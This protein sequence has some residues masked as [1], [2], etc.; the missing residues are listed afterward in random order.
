[1]PNVAA[2]CR[3]FALLIVLWRSPTRSRARAREGDFAATGADDDDNC[4]RREKHVPGTFSDR[5][6]MQ[7]P[8]FAALIRDRNYRG[9]LWNPNRGP[10]SA[11][12]DRLSLAIFGYN[13]PLAH[14]KP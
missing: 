7:K 14:H 12:E 9:P 5:R 6:Y 11:I 3:G 10:D 2:R 13:A 1:M 8:A 4:S